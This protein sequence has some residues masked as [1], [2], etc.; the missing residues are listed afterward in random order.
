MQ[1]IF[2][3]NALAEL[4]E[5]DRRTVQHALRR[6]KPDSHERKNPRW[7]MRTAIDALAAHE[8]HITRQCTGQNT[9]TF[10]L[11]DEIEAEFKAFDV[12]FATLESEPDLEKRRKLDEKLGVGKITG[13][14]D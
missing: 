8:Q 14:L 13:S 10:M 9:Q 12:G 11:I 7:R 6:I 3:I 2:S 4:L 5:K 1:Q